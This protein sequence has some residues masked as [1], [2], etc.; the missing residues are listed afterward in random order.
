M[1]N[2]AIA[3]SVAVMAAPFAT[4]AMAQAPRADVVQKDARGHAEKVR[5]DGRVYDVC[6]GDRMDDCINPRAA[7]LNWGNRALE[8][9]PGEPASEMH[10]R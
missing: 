9:W 1:K 10:R 3:I 2:I 8:T 5:V 6:R 7:G 4:P